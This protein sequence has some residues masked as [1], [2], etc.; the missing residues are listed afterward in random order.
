ML[1]EPSHHGLKC[2]RAMTELIFDFGPQFR[3]GG[4]VAVGDKERVIAKAAL[5]LFGSDDGAIDRAAKMGEHL[6]M[7]GDDH[8]TDKA[9]GA[10]GC[11]NAG[12]AGEQLGIVFGVIAFF[13]A[14]ARRP[15]AWGTREGVDL[16]SGVVR[17]H[18]PVDTAAD[19]Y[20]LE[21]GIFEKSRAR[22]RHLRE[23]G[24]I[25]GVFDRIRL[26][27][28]IADFSGFVG[29]PRGDDQRRSR[30]AENWHER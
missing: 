25:I 4:V 7:L 29:I 23:V 6:T 1:L 3:K 8:D 14:V 16:E 19:G 15:D 17:H 9:R 27:E 30:H 18:H 10:L 28:H 22:F 21:S 12:H 13:S 26:A 5:A 24:K 11:R 20:G 2:A